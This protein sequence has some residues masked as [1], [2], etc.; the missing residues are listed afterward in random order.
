MVK[1][2]K[3]LAAW[4]TPDFEAVFKDEVRRLGAAKLP[5]QQGLSQSSHVSGGDY[6]VVVLGAQEEGQFVRVRA[7]IFYQGV[8]AGCSCADDPTPV[9]TLTEYC[10][11]EFAIDKRTAEAEITLLEQD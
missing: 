10:V 7:G 8:I 4:H 9:D 5:L 6:D 3:S 2:E 11:L 1:L